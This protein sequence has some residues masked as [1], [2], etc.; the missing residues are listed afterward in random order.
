MAIMEEYKNIDF[1]NHYFQNGDT[2]L[3][4]AV[5]LHN[6]KFVYYLLQ[7]GFNPNVQN[8]LTRD[9]SLHIATQHKNIRMI[10]TLMKFKADITVRNLLD[11]TAYDIALKTDDDEILSLYEPEFQ[12]F[13]HDIEP[14]R[15]DYRATKRAT[16]GHNRGASK[17]MMNAFEFSHKMGLSNLFKKD[18]RKT[19]TTKGNKLVIP[20][21]NLAMI[22][23][24]VKS[25]TVDDQVKSD[26]FIFNDYDAN[27]YNNDNDSQRGSITGGL[28]PLTREQEIELLKDDLFNIDSNELNLSLVQSVSKKQQIALKT[29]KSIN[30]HCSPKKDKIILKDWLQKLRTNIYPKIYQKRYLF[31][32]DDYLC[33]N[34]KKVNFDPKDKLD[35]KKKE[36]I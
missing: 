20:N 13:L 36:R 32:L 16:F 34:D 2:C 4:Y 26:A 19:I 29:I 22:K 27:D 21:I 33:W 15:R 7:Q 9:T 30:N 11:K 12:V 3:H 23:E 18:Q 25:N 10:V 5:R 14:S 24:N 31:V 6:A 28:T 1:A 17:I 35:A 8:S